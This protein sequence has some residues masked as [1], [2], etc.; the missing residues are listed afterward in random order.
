MKFYEVYNHELEAYIKYKLLS[1]RDAVALGES[2]EG[3][4]REEYINEVIN[5]IVFNMRSELFPILR[6]KGAEE[7]AEIIN[8]IYLGGIMLNPALDFEAWSLAAHNTK[9]LDYIEDQESDDFDADFDASSTSSEL[10]IEA[11]SSTPIKKLPRS[12]ILSLEAHLKD[13]VIGQDES[14]EA[15]VSTLK[16]HAAGLGNEV[17]PLGTF[18][19]AGASGIGKTLFAKEI[20]NHLFGSIDAIIRVDCG[21]YQQKHDAH[22]LIG[23]PPSYVGHD[24]GGQLTN[25][26]IANPNSVILFDEIEKAHPDI[27]DMF[28]RV[29][30]DGVL[31]DS[32]GREVDMSNTIIIMTTNLGNE[33]I[34][35]HLTSKSAGF[36]AR[37]EAAHKTKEVLDH[38]V[39]EKYATKALKSF[40]RVEFLNRIN[41]ILVFNPLKEEQ[42]IHIA[43]LCLQ[44]LDK[45]LSKKG[46]VLKYDEAVTKKIAIEGSDSISNARGITRYR[47]DN[48]DCLLTEAILAERLPRGTLFFLILD[49]NGAICL[50]VA[51]PIA[52]RRKAQA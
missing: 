11:L 49:E 27:W 8:F 28:L 45:K 23:A 14:I 7:S 10:S 42:F 34:T 18:L 24:E 6:E 48:I 38:S 43:D 25:K 13:K 35:S 33:E 22:K 39:I 29:F 19:C 37:I 36:G 47:E 51:K 3:L 52:R 12:K 50:D 1:P 21:E 5:K 40:F 4:E 20:H 44:E 15:L 30:E 41:K 32:K 9:V 16:R 26:V 17:G 46:Y 31:S 2:L